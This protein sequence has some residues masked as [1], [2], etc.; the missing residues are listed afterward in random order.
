MQH[1]TIWKPFDH[2]VYSV[3]FIRNWQSEQKS[4]ICLVTARHDFKEIERPSRVPTSFL[5]EILFYNDIIKAHQ[6]EYTSTWFL[7]GTRFL[8]SVFLFFFCWR[9]LLVQH[10]NVMGSPHLVAVFDGC[11]SWMSL[12]L[13]SGSRPAH[14]CALWSLKWTHQCLHEQWCYWDGHITVQAPPS[15]FTHLCLSSLPSMHGLALW[16]QKLLLAYVL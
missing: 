2:C 5:T 9:L 14:P 15:F 6:V 8:K 13:L 1:L 11:T 3:E 7:D 4:T 16:S 10:S 12:R